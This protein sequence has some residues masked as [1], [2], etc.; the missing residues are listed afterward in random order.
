MVLAHLRG[1]LK[2]DY[3]NGVSSIIREEL[4]LQA[5]SQEVESQ[6][7]FMQANMKTQLLVSVKDKART[8]RE[9][10]DCLR[11]GTAL[12]RLEP[13]DKILRQVKAHSVDANMAA[14]KLLQKTNVFDILKDLLEKEKK[15]GLV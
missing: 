14:F 5:I 12:L 10:A 8:L 9:A 2:P 6:G 1:L 4:V 3:R 13:Y 15:N 11:M 7:L